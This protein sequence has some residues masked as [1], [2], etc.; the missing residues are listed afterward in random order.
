MGPPMDVRL[1]EGLGGCRALV[2]ILVLSCSITRPA[3]IRI[4]D[5]M[6]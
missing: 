2:K 1:M 3:S 5:M 4:F 6:L